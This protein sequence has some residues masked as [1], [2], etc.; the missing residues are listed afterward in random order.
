M[1]TS[2]NRVGLMGRRLHRQ[3]NEGMKSAQRPWGL[4]AAGCL[5]CALLGLASGGSLQAQEVALPGG[6]TSGGAAATPDPLEE[7]EIHI[8][9]ARS[10]GDEW[11]VMGGAEKDWRSGVKVEAAVKW[12][13]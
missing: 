7:L 5:A 2:A 12:S 9:R 3:A 6:G 8:T 1:V 13:V 10:L 11:S 4:R